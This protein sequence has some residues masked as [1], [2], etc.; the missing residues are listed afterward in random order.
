MVRHQRH[1]DRPAAL[2]Q[3]CK[4]ARLALLNE[5]AITDDVGGDNGGKPPLDAFFGHA[6]GLPSQNAIWRLYWHP[7]EESIGEDFRNGSDQFIYDVRSMSGLPSYADPQ[8]SSLQVPEVPKPTYACTPITPA[9]LL[10]VGLLY[11]WR[12]PHAGEMAA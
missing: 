4:R 7:V 10:V 2:L 3:C 11:T 6:M 8:S 9:T 5:A 12:G 1:Q